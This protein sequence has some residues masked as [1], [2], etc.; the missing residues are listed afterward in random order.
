M[1]AQLLTCSEMHMVVLLRRRLL[2]RRGLSRPP[3]P[4]LRRGLGTG[5]PAA[6]P[7]PPELRA[8]VA[9]PLVATSLRERGFAVL[10]GALGETWCHLLRDDI[11]T[12]AE[13]RALNRNATHLVK[14]DGAVELLAKHAIFE[15]E[16]HDASLRAACPWLSQLAGDRLLSAGLTEALRGRRL[17][18]QTMK[19]QLNAGGGACFPY[20]YDSDRAVDS[21]VVTAILYLNPDWEP[22]H[23][24]QLQLLPLP[25]AP[26]E[27]EPLF[28]R[29]CAPRRAKPRPPLAC[30]QAC[31]D[32]TMDG[33]RIVSARARTVSRSHGACVLCVWTMSALVVCCSRPWTCFIECYPHIPP[34]FA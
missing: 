19:I 4:E 5:A 1:G 21:R 23:G 3:P 20:H 6:L 29:L 14:S 13:M 18:R 11:I 17:A 34:D 12:L 8:R 31:D 15:T 22:A 10:D 26:V 32:P 2:P 24:G 16:L 28:D 27:V 30:T 33:C 25:L 7:L 9:T